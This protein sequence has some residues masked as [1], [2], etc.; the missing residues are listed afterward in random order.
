MVRISRIFFS[1]QHWQ[2]LRRSRFYCGHFGQAAQ[3]AFF[4]TELRL[5][6]RLNEIPRNA[7]TYRS[8]AHAEN[9]HVIVFHALSGREVVMNQGGTHSLHVIRADRSAYATSTDGNTALDFSLNDSASQGENI[10]WVVV[11]GRQSVCSKVDDL[12]A[13][14]HKF[15][16]EFF[17]EA[18]SSM[19]CRNAYAHFVSSP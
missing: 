15:G 14:L 7:R 5:E 8:T 18:K 4:G 6:K 17:L 3:V 12:M 16:H 1:T 2:R 10:V 19:I 9:I 11:V 13:G